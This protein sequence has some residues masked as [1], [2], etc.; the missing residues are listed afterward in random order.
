MEFLRNWPLQHYIT[1]DQ[2]SEYQTYYYDIDNDEIISEDEAEEISGSQD[3]R[4]NSKYLIIG[5]KRTVNNAFR[6]ITAGKIPTIPE[7]TQIIMAINQSKNEVISN[8][9]SK[10][11]STSPT[12]NNVLLVSLYDPTMTR[13]YLVPRDK[14]E[15]RHLQELE[16]GKATSSESF[17]WHYFFKPYRI[18]EK[19]VLTLPPIK[20]YPVISDR[21]PGYDTVDSENEY[22]DD[23]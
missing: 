21:S 18:S 1:L 16:S 17:H 5:L 20:V 22:D 23:F 12:S 7:Q 19:Q 11:I 4:L 14:L 9:L 8:L 10:Q 13:Y 2:V 6:D 3:Y 15:Q